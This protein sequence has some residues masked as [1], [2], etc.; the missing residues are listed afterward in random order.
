MNAAI[1]TKNALDALL[2]GRDD[3]FKAKVLDLV[4][5]NKWDA[6]DP[7][8]IITLATGQ[9]QILLE[10]MPKSFE[11]MSEKATQK[12]SQKLYEMQEWQA[13]QQKA[14]ATVTKTITSAGDHVIAKVK[15]STNEVVQEVK[16]SV[17]DVR[18]IR[19]DIASDMEQMQDFM[20]TL[21][22][23]HKESI[24]D[25]YMEQQ[26]LQAQLKILQKS[27][28]NI[29]KKQ[30]S[31]VEK[32]KNTVFWTDMSNAL[33]PAIWGASMAGAV[34]LGAIGLGVFFGDS[35]KYLEVIKANHSAMQGCFTEDGKDIN[36]KYNCEIRAVP[37]K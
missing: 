26:K 8:F 17:Q 7:S 19:N 35:Y 29:A 24:M 30:A 4:V 36:K 22:K 18:D 12:V 34:V 9:L 31:L 2:V 23:N 13:L 16:Q 20:V 5:K 32:L 21:H 14:F 6:D 33:P 15:D 37:K 28:E 27:G 3:T 25:L 1:K 10:D 11:S